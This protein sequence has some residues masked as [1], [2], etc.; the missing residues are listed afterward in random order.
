MLAGVGEPLP[1]VSVSV[2]SLVELPSGVR[3]SDDGV[4]VAIAPKLLVIAND[5]IRKPPVEGERHSGRLSEN[6][7]AGSAGPAG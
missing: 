4:L 2:A 7:L 5:V 1:G 6:T 3:S